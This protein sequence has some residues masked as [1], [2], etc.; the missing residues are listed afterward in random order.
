MPA[1]VEKFSENMRAALFRACID[2]GLS[3]RAAL[4]A[5][6]AREL[7]GL[8]SEDQQVLA[9]MAYG[10]AA[11]LVKDERDRRGEVAKVRADVTETAHD[12]AAELS[13]IAKRE[14]QRLGRMKPKT[15]AETGA[16]AAAGSA[17][18]KMQREALALARDASGQGKTNGK[19]SAPATEQPKAPRSLV[20]RIAAEADTADG[21]AHTT[22]SD[23]GDNG[24][25]AASETTEQTDNRGGGAVRLR[26]AA[27]A[28]RAPVDVAV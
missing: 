19:D 10:Y 8:S 3:V 1:F 23:S 11:T 14:Q 6:E 5:A 25:A 17:V 13:M 21:D 12:V 28:A 18:L 16:L 20:A 22:P 15:P 24:A 7:E 9:T 26:A 4:R 2:N 27:P